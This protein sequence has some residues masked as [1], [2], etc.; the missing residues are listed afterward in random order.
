MGTDV[1]SS[2]NEVETNIVPKILTFFLPSDFL[3]L[4]CSEVISS[5]IVCNG[6]Q[7][8]PTG[9]IIMVIKSIIGSC[10]PDERIYC[11]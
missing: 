2:L 8:G 10:R 3:L 11:N 1:K 6:R 5:P 4:L 7:K 9:I